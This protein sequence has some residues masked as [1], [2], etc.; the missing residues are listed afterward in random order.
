MNKDIFPSVNK[1]IT[2]HDQVIKDIKNE[3]SLKMYFIENN[4]TILIYTLLYGAVLGLYIG[5]YQILINSIKL[6]ILFF[7]TLYI[8]LPVFYILGLLSGSKISFKQ[9]VVLIISGYAIAS[10]IMMAFTPVVLF[11]IL[12]AKDYYFTIFLSIGILGLSGYFSLIYIFKNF[13]S[14]HKEDRRWYPSMIVGSLIIIFVGTQLS[15]T[16]RPFFHTYEDFI[17]P[18]QGNFYMAVAKGASEHPYISGAIL[19]LFAFFAILIT[20]IYYIMEN[21]RKQTP[22]KQDSQST[23]NTTP[24]PY[25]Q[26]TYP[27]NP[28]QE[29][30]QNL[31]KGKPVEGELKENLPTTP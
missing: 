1:L 31:V 2:N 14:F 9:M 29:F 10:I 25:P 27:A 5:G 19:L 3:K 28:N 12:T 26:Y 4:I 23:T 6:P 15:W 16:L 20:I 21:T 22:M 8:S 24:P 11:F 7:I 18:P 30:Q 13:N 17:R